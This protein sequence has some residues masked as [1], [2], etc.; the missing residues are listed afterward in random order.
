MNHS[1]AVFLKNHIH[2]RLSMYTKDVGG[3]LRNLSLSQRWDSTL[4]TTEDQYYLYML[5]IEL[6]NSIYKEKFKA[7]EYKIALFPHC[8]RELLQK[9]RMVV[10]DIEH[11]CTGCT[12]TCFIRRASD[13]LKRYKIRPYIWMT[14]N[15]EKALR[16]LKAEHKSFGVL[17]IACIPELMMGMRASV[18][19]DIP[20]VGIPL[21]AN[22]CSRWMGNFYENSFSLEQLKSLIEVANLKALKL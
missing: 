19:M 3:H 8:L 12:E 21:N 18:K 13:L 11:V 10:G 1:L 7:C 4:K 20:V 17:G 6:V 16:K 5:E 22:R 14:M 9:C 15:Y 2:P